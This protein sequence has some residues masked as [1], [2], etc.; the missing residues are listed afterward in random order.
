MPAR[1]MSAMD[2]AGLPLQPDR[3]AGEYTIARQKPNAAH[4]DPA[5]EDSMSFEGLDVS[6]DASESSFPAEPFEINPDP[7]SADLTCSGGGPRWEHTG[8]R[9]SATGEHAF[10]SRAVEQAWGPGPAPAETAVLL[11]RFYPFF[12]RVDPPLSSPSDESP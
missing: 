7:A 4:T 2:F 1:N 8:D 5:E 6:H 11:Y 3:A 12:L 10:E 9:H